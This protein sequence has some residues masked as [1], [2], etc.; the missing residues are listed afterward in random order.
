MRTAA[1]AAMSI[2]CA[3][4][5]VAEIP[6]HADAELGFD[7]RHM[8]YGRVENDEPI[9]RMEGEV[10]CLDLFHIGIESVH[11]LDSRGR[12]LELSPSAGVGHIFTPDDAGWLP[13][14]VELS[15]DY[16]YEHC[17]REDDGQF[18]TFGIGLPAL[19]LEPAF[20]WEAETMRDCGNYLAAE[21]GHTFDLTRGISLRLSAWEGW[22][23]GRRNE[24]GAGLMDT[25][26]RA[27]VN[28]RVTERIGVSAYAAYCDY[29]H[30]ADDRTWLGGAF[31]RFGF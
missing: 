7:S 21:V 11:G 31:V 5:A 19:I 1:I 22:G 28:Y 13:T 26:I 30:G 14:D 3:A 2:L 18:I 8:K 25:R 4:S 16:L 24:R 29:F 6:V 20:L 23:D 10:E 17:A 15:A 27:C 12:C 9:Y